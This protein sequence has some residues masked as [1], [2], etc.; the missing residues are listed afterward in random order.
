MGKSHPPCLDWNEMPKV[1]AS[2]NANAAP[3]GAVR[4]DRSRRQLWRAAIKW[5]IYSVAVMPALVAAGWLLGPGRRQGWQLEV[6]QL[7]AFMLAALLLLAWENLCNDRFDA[8]TGIDVN[9]P[10]SLVR[11][12]NAPHTVFWCAQGCLVLGLLLMARVAA[13]SSWWVLALVLGCCL[14]GYLY[15]GPPF[16]L[17]Y[18][19]LGEP[20]CWLAF[21][22]LATTAALAALGGPLDPGLASLLGAGPAVATTLVLFCSHFH[23]VDD[24][25][26]HGKRSLVQRLGTA[27]AAALIPWFVM[28]TLVTEVLIPIRLGAWWPAACLV[29]VGLP[30]ALSLIRLLRSHHHQPERISGSKF[31]A[32]RFQAFSGFAL[33]CGLAVG[34]RGW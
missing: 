15:Q 16:R 32:L 21:G 33:A 22:P 30:P 23:Q 1:V 29:L 20:L 2:R 8:D 12:T 13:A 7:A 18:R 26:A 25:L 24:D 14:C 6:D 34:G 11:L 9:K 5:P 17:G 19:G 31:L 4:T 10:H 3:T 27:R 28:L